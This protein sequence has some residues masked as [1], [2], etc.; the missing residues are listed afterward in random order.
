MTRMPVSSRL[1]RIGLDG[2]EHELSRFHGAARGWQGANGYFPPLHLVGPRAKFETPDL[3]CSYTADQQSVELVWVG[4]EQVPDGF[5]QTRP[6]IHARVAGWRDH[7]V[8]VLQQAG[9][10][11]VRLIRD[12]WL[13]EQRP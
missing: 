1:I 7:R 5:S 9:E 4:N 11:N 8:R 13:E 2:T 3:P 12:I 10:R 6:M